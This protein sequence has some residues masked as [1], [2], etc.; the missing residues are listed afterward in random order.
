M[1]DA[2]LRLD[3][4]SPK[5]KQDDAHRD[6]LAAFQAPHGHSC[7]RP[8]PSGTQDALQPSPKPVA[9]LDHGLQSGVGP[10]GLAQLDHQFSEPGLAS[11]SPA[12]SGPCLLSFM[13][14]SRTPR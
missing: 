11:L 5:G 13:L 2:I 4:E 9:Q 7:R 1:A 6:S 8:D 14:V 12:P 3:L 10:P